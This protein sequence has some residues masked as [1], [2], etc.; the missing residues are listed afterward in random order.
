[1]AGIV[2][3]FNLQNGNVVDATQVMANFAAI[4]AF[5]NNI[6]LSPLTRPGRPVAGG[7]PVSGAALTDG[8]VIVVNTSASPTTYRLPPLP[9]QQQWVT[10]KDGSALA[11]GFQP[12]PCTVVTVDG[13][14]IDLTNGSTGVV[15]RSNGDS[16]DFVYLGTQWWRA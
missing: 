4:V 15:L 1:M 10:V 8:L 5:V 9:T 12:Y 3:P 2:L 16:Q 7:G 11:Y 13:S 14:Q 6:Q